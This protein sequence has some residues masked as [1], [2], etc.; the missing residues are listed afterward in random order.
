M[1]TS[2]GPIVLDSGLKPVTFEIEKPA[3][4]D[5]REHA[6]ALDA[7]LA[8]KRKVHQ[9]A[10][11]M[12]A[13]AGCFTD[14]ALVAQTWRAC[15]D[16]TLTFDITE[17]MEGMRGA[18]ASVV[19]QTIVDHVRKGND[20]KAIAREHGAKFSIETYVGSPRDPETDSPHI[21]GC[22]HLEVTLYGAAPADYPRAYRL[23]LAL[24]DP[25]P[26]APMA[27]RIEL[28]EWAAVALNYWTERRRDYGAEYSEGVRRLP[29][30]PDDEAAEHA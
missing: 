2:T 1:V 18:M 29:A 26:A 19:Y 24:H 17:G 25:D 27:T 23:P 13:V 8:L 5:R 14:P 30:S 4:I 6:D 11:A 9:Q 21:S 15:T 28:E 20:L 3:P 10:A 16:E 7:A 22:M 12:G